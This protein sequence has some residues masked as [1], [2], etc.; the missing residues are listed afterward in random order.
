MRNFRTLSLLAFAALF[1]S[2]MMS[3][4][5]ANKL[6][7]QDKLILGKWVV[8]SVDVGGET[9]PAKSLGGSILFQ[10]NRDGTAFFTTPDGQIERGRY[11]IHSGQIYDPDSPLDAPVDIVNLTRDELIIS[12]VEQGEQMKMT[13]RPD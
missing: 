12:M 1:F 6:H 10:F 11:A 8:E 9:V 5:T 7:K 3:C 4:A 2:Q 13:L